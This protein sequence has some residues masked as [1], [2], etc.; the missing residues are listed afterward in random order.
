MEKCGKCGWIHGEIGRPSVCPEEC[1]QRGVRRDAEPQYRKG[2]GM[3]GN[4]V[5][6][7][8]HI[9]STRH[10]KYYAEVDESLKRIPPG[11]K[12]GTAATTGNNCLIHSLYQAATTKAWSKSDAKAEEECARI[13]RAIAKKYNAPPPKRS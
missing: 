9:D 11:S 1:G 10:D 8:F 5:T 12:I 6:K 2:K 13:R 7:E 4:C 3:P